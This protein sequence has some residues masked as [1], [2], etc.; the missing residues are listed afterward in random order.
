LGG[1]PSP[2]W[3]KDRIKVTWMRLSRSGIGSRRAIAF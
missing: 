2:A 1:K 3:G